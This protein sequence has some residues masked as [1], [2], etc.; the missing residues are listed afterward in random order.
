MKRRD[1]IIDQLHRLR[2]DFGRAHDFDVRRI[3]AAIRQR[4]DDSPA[5]II[6]EPAEK[7]TGQ[8]KASDRACSP[9]AQRISSS[10]PRRIAAMTRG[11][12]LP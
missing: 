3:A 11:L 9:T 12:R 10:R 7:A 4:E 2:E 1:A 6:H 5:G 8:K